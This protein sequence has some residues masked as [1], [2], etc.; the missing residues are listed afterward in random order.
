MHKKPVH[1]EQ[2]PSVSESDGS[3]RGRDRVDTSGT[4]SIKKIWSSTVNNNTLCPH[5]GALRNNL[6]INQ[7][8]YL[9]KH[10]KNNQKRCALHMW[11]NKMHM[12][13]HILHCA[14][15]NVY[16]CVDCFT[17]FHTIEEVYDLQC[18]FINPVMDVQTIFRVGTTMRW[19]YCDGI[20]SIRHINN[21][22]GLATTSFTNETIH[23]CD[24]TKPNEDLSFGLKIINNNGNMSDKKHY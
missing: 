5:T 15:C 8:T 23:H 10:P 24:Q 3:K 17:H 14:T 20:V 11:G 18:K 19:S 9:P 7:G 12:Q 1:K 4:R 2:E 13:A 21:V 6:A 16:L 22:T